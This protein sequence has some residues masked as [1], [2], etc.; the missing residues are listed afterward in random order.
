[1]ICSG[2]MRFTERPIFRRVELHI[3]YRSIAASFSMIQAMCQPF[4][5]VL[6]HKSVRRLLFLALLGY[7][8]DFS[9]TFHAF[10]V[11]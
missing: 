4:L 6:D 1:M 10:F 8:F 7:V 11:D 9:T 5:G 3:S 2:M